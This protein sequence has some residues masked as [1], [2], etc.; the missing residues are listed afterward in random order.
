MI[1]IY[2]IDWN[3]KKRGVLVLETGNT[4]IVER[5]AY[6]QQNNSFF[7]TFYLNRTTGVSLIMNDKIL[8]QCYQGRTVNLLDMLLEDVANIYSDDAVVYKFIYDQLMGSNIGVYVGKKPLEHNMRIRENAE[9]DYIPYRVMFYVIESP[10]QEIEIIGYIF[11][12]TERSVMEMTTGVQLQTQQDIMQP[13]FAFVTS[14][15]KK[16]TIQN[17]ALITVDIE[18]FKMVND[19]HGDSIGDTILVY[20]G[21]CI[22]I[23]LH[24]DSRYYVH[25]GSDVFVLFVEYATQAQL[26][27]TLKQWDVVMNHYNDITYQ[28]KWGVALITDYNEA[29][30]AL[31]DK[32]TMARKSIKGN[33]L[34]NIE[35]YQEIQRITMKQVHDVE[36]K[37]Y[38]A[39]ENNEFKMYI[40][41]KFDIAQNKI[42]GGEA[43]VRWVDSVTG[44]II[45]PNEFI[46]I[47]ESNGFIINVDR[48]IWREACKAL[49]KWQGTPLEK[50]PLSVNVSR[51]HLEDD[52]FVT[53]L[54]DLIKEYGIDRSKL[55][56]EITETV[57]NVCNCAA[58]IKLR[59]FGFKALMDDFGSGYSSLNTLKTTDFDV[60][61]LDKE[62]LSEYMPNSRGQKIIAHT[63]SMIRDINLGVVA[64]GVETEEQA[65]FLRN[66]GCT[67]VQGFL[68]SKAVPLT[69]FESL[70]YKREGTEV[71]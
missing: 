23:F 71:K 47:F 60:I 56:I 16:R 53:Y 36:A 13:F 39:L 27:T 21:S 35:I 70:Y 4:E 22:G 5:L 44:T 38:S 42:I 10:K 7:S 3:F 64:E 69:D 32:S 20:M 8:P 62:F 65:E 25:Q 57:D 49:K 61:K 43:L 28:L 58:F 18:N 26:M 50:I 52:S 40:Q 9:S 55:E 46:P 15:M 2:I 63:I 1:C 51:R 54:D 29:P 34:K 31:L 48:Y 45:A 24:G 6:I 14:R 19:T 59:E 41:P 37:M 17:Y 66:H 12:T 11:K 30:R 67:C 33:A 68:Y